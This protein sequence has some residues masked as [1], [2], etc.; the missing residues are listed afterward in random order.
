MI[1]E[2]LLSSFDDALREGTSSAADS[3]LMR[4][5]FE[6]ATADLY[7]RDAWRLYYKLGSINDPYPLS[8]WIAREFPA[9]VPEKSVWAKVE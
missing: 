8:D 6:R 9:W 3:T 4:A 7:D 1:L 5:I 2:C